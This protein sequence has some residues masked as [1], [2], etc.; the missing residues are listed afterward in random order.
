MTNSGA[1]SLKRS[2]SDGHK[3]TGKERDSESGLDYFGARH[4]A[5][6][7]GRW[8]SPDIINITD[9]RVLNPVNT[10]NKYV[11]GGNNPL[12][13]IDS[14]GRDITI[15]YEAGLPTGHVML[16]AYNQETGDFAFMSVGPQV[17]RDPGALF[18]PFSG[19]LGTSEYKLPTS[20]DE[21][22]QKFQALTIQTTPE[23]AQQAIDAIRGGAGT[24][25]WAALGNNCASSCV[26]LL[27]EIGLSPG[28]NLGL[29]WTPERFWENIKAKYGNSA[30]P[31]SRF[32]ANTI[33][34]GSFANVHNG[35]DF[36]RPRYPTNTFDWI[37]LMLNSAPEGTV[38]TREEYWI[39][40]EKHPDTSDCKTGSS[41]P[42]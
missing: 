31:F 12:K 38:R 37:I 21:L 4:N 2:V 15:F 34:A 36:G 27:K 41:T 25:N 23:V 30:S 35:I 29:P 1:C 11:H 22:R 14:D 24:G 42:N 17:P 28:S 5:S 16:A 13:Y 7:L 19:V 20:V 40:C 10:L 3:F 18:H 6:S 33:G 9:D 26:K 39:R 8:M 32:M